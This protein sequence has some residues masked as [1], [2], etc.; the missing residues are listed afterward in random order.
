MFGNYIIYQQLAVEEHGSCIA[1]LTWIQ[2]QTG[3]ENVWVAM[4]EEHGCQAV[5]AGVERVWVAVREKH[6]CQ[7]VWTGC[8][9]CRRGEGV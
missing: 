5:W 8:C 4:R 2:R 3:V 7:A 9:P 1:S 6:G